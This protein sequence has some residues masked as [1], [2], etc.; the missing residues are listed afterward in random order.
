LYV[1]CAGGG[2]IGGLMEKDMLIIVTKQE[3][4]TMNQYLNQL[5]LQDRFIVLLSFD[6]LQFNILNHQYVPP[7]TIL[8]EEERD[9]M[10]KNITLAMRHSCRIFRGIDRVQ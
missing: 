7:H 8:S 4:K 6:W 3:V 1:L 10:M 2:E 5:F 9:E